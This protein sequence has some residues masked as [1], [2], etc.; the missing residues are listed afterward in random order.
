MEWEKAKTVSKSK[1]CKV[2][3]LIVLSSLLIA[4][5]YDWV[6]R[7]KGKE[8]ENDSFIYSCLGKSVF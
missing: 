4:Q 8:F 6:N 1:L 5:T 3:F 2:L 7:G